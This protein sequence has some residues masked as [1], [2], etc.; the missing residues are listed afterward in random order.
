MNKNNVNYKVALGGVISALCL[1]F[2]FFTA[3]S[4]VLYIVMPMLAGLMLMVMV[5]ET[6]TKWAVTT[7]FS[8]SIL[9]ILITFNKEAVLMFIIFFG[10]YPVLKQYLDKIRLGF[11]RRCIK[12]ILFNVCIIADFFI[13]IKIFG[14][15]DLIDEMNDYG[16]YGLYILLGMTDL[17]FCTYD[18]ALANCSQLYLKWFRPK[19]LCK[20]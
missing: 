9:S 2:M 14:I 20:K 17:T 8:V 6:D 15:T 4:P 7:Y 19:I 5:F 18:I 3:L 10:Y 16:K 11:F 12:F 13:T 1:M